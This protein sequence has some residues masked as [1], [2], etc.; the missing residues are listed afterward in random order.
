MTPKDSIKIKLVNGSLVAFMPN[1]EKL[2]YVL[3]INVSSKKGSVI[4]ANI[5]VLVD[6]SQ[7]NEDEIIESQCGK[8]QFSI[9]G[10]RLIAV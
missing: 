7:M 2:P 10:N 1:G 3:D 8:V 4:K 5:E 6:L 9:D